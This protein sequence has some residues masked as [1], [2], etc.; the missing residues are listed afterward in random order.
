MA[1][2][3]LAQAPHVTG[4]KWVTAE[5]GRG[6]E[7]LRKINGRWWSED[8]REV[9]APPPGGIFWTLDSKPG[10]VEFVHHRPFQLARAESLRLWMDKLSVQSV[11]GEP[12][13]RF[14]SD[15]HAHWYYYA[16]DGTKLEVWFVD[17]GV[18]GDAKYNVIGQGS[19]P[20][21]SVQRDLGGQDLFKLL[22][23]RARQRSGQ[24]QAQKQAENR[25]DQLARSEMLR[26]GGRPV[27]GRSGQPGV[28]TV[29][30]VE[31]PRAIEP[32]PAK[33]R[34]LPAASLDGIAVGM[35]RDDLLTKLGEPTGR[36]A[37]SDD[38]GTRE[39][40]TYDLDSGE[41]VVVRLLNGK[42]TKVR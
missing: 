20:V 1:T 33:K 30:N 11:L 8:N 18:L 25:A 38:E 23:E 6:K 32:D 31:V 15:D 4:E 21:A 14:G 27:A 40:F 34:I 42:V 28:V 26:H 41:S 9:Y 10:V 39:S 37:I 5:G 17:N 24:W 36:Y 12:N 3:L 13:R 19:W 7:L 2:V 16:A 35:S 29:S 22:A